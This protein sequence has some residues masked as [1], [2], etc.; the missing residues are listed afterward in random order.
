MHN[1]NKM[2]SS[3]ATTKPNNDLCNATAGEEAADCRSPL[4]AAQGQLLNTDK[5]TQSSNTVP[6]TSIDSYN[7]KILRT[8]IDSL[9]LSYQGDLIE[10]TA[11]RLTELKKMAQSPDPRITALAQIDINNHIFEVK[12]RGR[13]PFAFILNDNWYRIEIAKLGAVRTPLAH[14]QV[15]S[16]LLTEHGVEKSV[17]DLNNIVNDLGI[18]SES[19]AVSRLDLCVD[20]I[21][22]YPLADI[23]DGDWVT[24]AKDM[25]RY[26]V[27]RTFSGWV[28]GIGG[29]IVARLY[30]KTLEMQKKPRYYLETIHRECGWDG[31]SGVWR[32]E[33][34]FR[35]V[36]LRELGIKSFSSLKESL[37][38]LWQ[39]ASTDWL[40]L[41]IPS[42]TDKTQSRWPTA[43]VWEVLQQ[44]EWSG[45]EQV[46]RVPV[47]K[48]RPPSDRSLFVNGISGLTSFMAREGYSDPI[49]GIHS[50]I[51]SAK[52]Y[53]DD[54]EYM[55]DFDFHGYIAQKVALKVKSYNTYLNMPEDKNLHPS[56]KAVAD[57][58]RKQSDGE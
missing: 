50:Y 46:S 26:T 36:A 54:R 18:L 22:D 47:E 34:Q 3:K 49:E 19:P 30:N 39:Y 2:G 14:V 57:E 32:L 53:H 7:T 43:C 40:R 33:F 4:P 17:S 24:R 5:G 58:Y 51:R 11:I 20:F 31:N 41:T 55:T 48:G 25:D 35:R 27:Q 9:Y 28:I 1:D 23:V 38:G 29:N 56:E 6:S 37:A 44:A 21:T 52:K 15:M 8:G 12:D 10:E 45:D 16:E 42:K 13:H